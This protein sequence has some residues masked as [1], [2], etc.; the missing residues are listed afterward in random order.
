MTS[1][2]ITVAN[3]GGGDPTLTNTSSSET[4]LS[5]DADDVDANNLGDYRLTVDRT[6]LIE[7]IYQATASFEFDTA[8]TLTIT[9]SMQVGSLSSDGE[10]PQL[11]LVAVNQDLNGDN[12]ETFGV[13]ELDGSISFSFDSIAQGT[14]QLF[15]GSDIDNDLILCQFGE[16][17][18]AFPTLNEPVL[19]TIEEDL[20]DI[21]FVVEIIAGFTGI[22]AT[23]ASEGSKSISGL[24]VDQEGIPRTPKN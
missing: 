4:W 11:Y 14:Y 7:G 10:A 6:D 18:G 12:A 24:E 23:Q 9:V 13:L 16:S 2:I 1:T 21:S 5:I 22:S 15:A 8:N 19:I 20:E 3:T 17:C